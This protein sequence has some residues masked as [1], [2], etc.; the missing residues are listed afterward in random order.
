MSSSVVADV[1]RMRDPHAHRNPTRQRVL[2]AAAQ[3]LDEPAQPDVSLPSLAARARVA[4]TALCAHFPSIDTV[5]AEL[6]LHHVSN[7][8]LTVN[9]T[10]PIGERVGTQLRAITL[11]LADRPGLARACTRALLSADDPSVADVRTRIAAE[12][13]R[14][15]SA[16][17][18]AGAWPE[19]LATL[20]TVFW[21]ALLQA[22]SSD[23]GYRTVANRLD[24]MLS[25]ILPGADC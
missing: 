10:A 7:L 24:T 11:V 15:L 2:G 23:I 17:M 18:G 20:E 21:G 5:F 19:V 1:I 22:Q 12:I 25:L 6:Y 13:R 3:M 16:A 4:Q 8:P 9:P 14:R